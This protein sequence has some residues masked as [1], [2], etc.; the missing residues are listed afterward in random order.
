MR[1]IVDSV[2]EFS[3]ISTLWSNMISKTKVRVSRNY[4]NTSKYFT[5]ILNISINDQL[6]LSGLASKLFSVFYY[7]FF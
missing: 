1:N 7:S 6:I 2:D 4:Y 5:I 3:R